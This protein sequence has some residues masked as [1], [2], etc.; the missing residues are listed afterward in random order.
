MNG[1]SYYYRQPGAVTPLGNVDVVTS[2]LVLGGRSEEAPE[3]GTSCQFVVSTLQRD[4]QLMA[5][6]NREMMTWLSTLQTHRREYITRHGTKESMRRAKELSSGRN[7]KPQPF[8][9]EDIRL[10]G[11]FAVPGG[12]SKGPNVFSGLTTGL[13]NLS[14]L[15]TLPRPSRRSPA[16]YAPR[17][18]PYMPLPQ[19]PVAAMHP[20]PLFCP[21]RLTKLAVSGAPPSQPLTRR[22]RPFVHMRPQQ[23]R[24]Q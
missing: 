8:R 20:P 23:Q 3:N 2:T 21:S 19:V 6:N 11:T 4:Y 22:H 24:H 7:L 14:K 15:A 5:E 9:T 13:S 1:R 12:H 18:C 10:V 17:H 16:E